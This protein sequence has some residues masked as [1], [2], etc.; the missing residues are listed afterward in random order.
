[1]LFRS[2]VFS[3]YG[4]RTRLNSKL[5]TVVNISKAFRG[6]HDRYPT[7]LNDIANLEDGAAGQWANR[8]L[9]N[10]HGDRYEFSLFTN[11]IEV[12][13]LARAIFPIKEVSMTKRLE[14]QND[15]LNK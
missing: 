6:L 5:G 2:V 9:T 15:A 8:E 3:E 4:R 1:M 14:F 12:R 7:N 11:S 13:V 10:F